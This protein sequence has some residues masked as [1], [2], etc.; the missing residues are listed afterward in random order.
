MKLHESFWPAKRGSRIGRFLFGIA[1]LSMVT[2]I[3]PS[4]S[5]EQEILSTS[6]KNPNPPTGWVKKI[7]RGKVWLH[8]V[9][10]PKYEWMPVLDGGDERESS[11]VM[12]SGIAINPNL[13][14]ADFPW[15]HPFS[16]PPGSGI[17]LWGD[18]EFMVAPDYDARN[19]AL[20][21]P[22]NAGPDPE[23]QDGV[24]T[25]QQM[26]LS[27]RR[28]VLGVETDQNLVPSE[29]RVS[30]GD[31]VVM[32]GRW[33]VDCGHADFHSE[34]HPPLLHVR[35]RSVMSTKEC[36]NSEL[37]HP[38][39]EA[40]CVKLIGRPYLVSQEFG[41][42]P[43]SS[44]LI[45]EIGKVYCSPPLLPPCS[46]DLEARALTTPKPFRDVK[47][48]PLDIRPP[49][50]RHTPNDRLI[51]TL[52]FTVRTAVAVELVQGIDELTILISMREDLYK[53]PDLPKKPVIEHIDSTAL[54]KLDPG[55]GVGYQFIVNSLALPTDPFK[56]L[57]LQKG[58]IAH[59]YSAQLPKSS[60]DGEIIH[61]ELSQLPSH[62]GSV[63]DSQPYPIYGFANLEWERH[64]AT[65]LTHPVGPN[66]YPNP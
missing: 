65:S 62:T 48:F 11:T 59:F 32:F 51:V 58:V 26:G 7:C 61:A 22:S 15:T 4:S 23:Y 54:L 33:I 64:P 63:D 10:G 38:N 42:G 18:Y 21:A 24:H 12:V 52:H 14:K 35:S 5:T 17:P 55:A 6:Y 50:P 2:F 47:I 43:F 27:V 66:P 30:G 13:S 40:T 28:G 34:I 20:L 60:H 9:P 31:R 45:K 46:L 37:A 8:D 53:A 39:G 57:I 3:E 25:A 56:A 1:A 44:H 29:Y 19:F 49:S 41:D 16:L 36:E